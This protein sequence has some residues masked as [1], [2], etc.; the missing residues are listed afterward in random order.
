MFIYFCI[1]NLKSPI[2]FIYVRIWTSPTPET[3][4]YHDMYVYTHSSQRSENRRETVLV[5]A[6]GNF[7]HKTPSL[8][9][10][11]TN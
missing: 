5:R 10:V 2:V 8:Q 1:F 4:L 11:F 7:I 9:I 6:Y 3:H